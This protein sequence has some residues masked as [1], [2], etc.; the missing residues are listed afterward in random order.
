MCAS[1]TGNRT[2]GRVA[3]YPIDIDPEQIVRWL[4][5]EQKATP[6]LFRFDARVVSEVREIPSSLEYHLGDEE[7]ENLSEVDTIATLE[8]RPAHP[9][10]GWT[11][12]V[13]VED[14]AGPR[15]TN[16]EIGTGSERRI[17][18]G[19]FYHHFI[20]AGRGIATATA[21]VQDVGGERHL[22]EL[23]D[24][25]LMDRHPAI[26]PAGHHT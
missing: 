26:T 10:E 21:E 14:E 25:I 11:L 19:S 12:T 16:Q 7:R 17:D 22:K 1:A 23:L 13:T 24:A 2:E 5:A 4:V 9:S 18:L 15:I 20:R 6:S 3:T 8:V